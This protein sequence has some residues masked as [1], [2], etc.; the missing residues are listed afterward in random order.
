MSVDHR[1]RRCLVDVLGVDEPSIA[2]GLPL[3]DIDDWDS[4]NAVRLLTNLERHLGASLDY[5][6][7]MAAETVGDVSLLVATTEAATVR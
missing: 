3:A 1:V 6:A 2:E 4:L 7:F 5:E